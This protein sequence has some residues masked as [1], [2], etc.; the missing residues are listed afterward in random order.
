M[1]GVNLL[2]LP[3]DLSAH[4]PL[5]RYLARGQVLEIRVRAGISTAALL[6]VQ[7]N[8][9]HV[10]SIDADPSCGGVYEGH[11]LWTFHGHSRDDAQRIL[12][13]LP[14]LGLLFIDGDHGWEMVRS[15]SS[16]RCRFFCSGA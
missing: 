12:G 3:C 5:L 8:G 9:G 6:G 2:N 7:E 1:Y 10:Y 4:L 15:Y 11:Q 14:R 16:A 13:L